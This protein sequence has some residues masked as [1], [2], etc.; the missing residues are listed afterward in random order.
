MFSRSVMSCNV[1]AV[2]W[3]VMLGCACG[4]AREAPPTPGAGAAVAISAQALD[5]IEQEQGIYILG[6]EPDK[7]LGDGR[8]FRV[9]D[10]VNVVA[11]PSH[12]GARVSVTPASKGSHLV[13]TKG[14][15]EYSGLD[16]WL[17]GMILSGVDGGQVRVA[18]GGITTGA[19]TRYHLWYRASSK[20]AWTEYCG[21]PAAGDP[22]MLAV[23]LRGWYDGRRLH[24]DDDTITFAC[25]NGVASKCTRWGYVAGNLG[26]GDHDW[27]RHQACTRMANADS[28]ADGAPKTRE[29]TP[30]LIRDYDGSP[31]LTPMAAPSLTTPDPLPGDP[32]R[33]HFEAGWG[34]RG[35]ICLAK[36]RWVALPPDPCPGVLPDPRFAEGRQ[37]GGRFC[38]ELEIAD[39]D[40]LGALLAN[41]SKVMDAP[42]HVWRSDAVGN[43]V[44]VTMQGYFALPGNPS[45]ASPAPPAPPIEQVAPFPSELCAGGE[46]CYRVHLGV[47]SMVLR[48]L[49]GSLDAT[50]DMVELHMWQRPVGAG[51]DRVIGLTSQPAP[52]FGDAGFEAYAFQR[53]NQFPPRVLPALKLCRNGN[54]YY[55][56]IGSCATVVAV[57][58]YAL[59]PP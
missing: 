8:H 38:D 13:A 31:N 47:D 21:A 16:R 36:R 50:T 14:G 48:N 52:G 3:F 58:G 2:S 49:P 51:F 18:S 33:H 5:G 40:S 26:P 35:A 41:G 20:D 23:P 10:Q 25:D 15:V 6:S 4:T 42:L 39:L 46:A 43:D 22:P 7:W 17:E 54:R 12:L 56:T 24:H 1:A 53:A 29:K 27:D 28:C 44:A 11:D 45:P 9:A 30:I 37:A 19:I 34:P 57:L 59:P 55:N 32:D